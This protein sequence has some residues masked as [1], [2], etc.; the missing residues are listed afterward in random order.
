[1][2]IGIDADPG[3]FE[4][5]VQLTAALKAVAMA[6]QVE[7]GLRRSARFGKIGRNGRRLRQRPSAPQ[8][9]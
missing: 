3:G 2:C 6:K 5:K 4:L 9:C 1:M 7:T 8:E